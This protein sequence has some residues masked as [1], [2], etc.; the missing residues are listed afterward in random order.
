MS[1]LLLVTDIPPTPAYT[2]GIVLEQ[3]CSFIPSSQLACFVVA[4]PGL[5][6][7]KISDSLLDIP[8]RQAKKPREYAVRIGPGKVGATTALVHERWTKA[9][10]IPP[11]VNQ[12][13]KFAREV[14]ATCLW[15]VLQGQTMIRL[16]RPLAEKTGLP[17]LTEVWDP[18]AWWLRDRGMEKYTTR[19]VLKEF[20]RVL[21]MSKRCATASIPMAER[22]QRYFKVD[23]IPFLPSLDRSCVV[24]S[25]R[26][27]SRDE[28]FVISLSG[29]IYAQEEWNNLLGALNLAGW[30][31]G[32]RNVRVRVYGRSFNLATNTPV[33][34]EFCGWHS[35][36]DLISKLTESDVLYCPY[37]FSPLFEDESR[38]SFPSKLT[39]YLTTRR[40]VFFHGPEYAA[41][42]Q[43]LKYN[44][45]GYVCDSLDPKKILQGLEKLAED[46]KYA[47]EVAEN[48]VQAFYNHL[49]L[50]HLKVS[51][52]KFIEGYHAG[53]SN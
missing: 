16:A 30:K 34:I 14:E 13:A 24:P 2:A 32:D 23:S 11:L 8:Y 29:Q 52:L 31:I 38:L 44:R 15:V 7:L 3:L 48:G 20:E 26:E 5:T 22:Y 6:D 49:T 12:V 1:K 41:P 28:D 33:H 47:S 27:K 17:L 9:T 37:W 45:A 36:A 42:A 53:P 46:Q 43:F 51:F 21:S 4:N 19:Q 50:D 25:V 35:Q 40:P 18:P 10:A 39:S